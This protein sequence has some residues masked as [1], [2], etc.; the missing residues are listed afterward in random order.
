MSLGIKKN[1][2]FFF[3]SEFSIVTVKMLI[4][5]NID[6]Q[7]IYHWSHQRWAMLPHTAVT[8]QSWAAPLYRHWDQAVHKQI[9]TKMFYIIIIQN[10]KLNIY[11]S[12]LEWRVYNIFPA[13]KL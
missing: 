1:L 11:Y 13:L 5:L 4:T 10:E 6:L 3:L 2:T 9:H 7:D 12:I 8:V